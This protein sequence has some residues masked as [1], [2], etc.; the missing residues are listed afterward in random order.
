MRLDDFHSTDNQRASMHFSH[1]P[2]LTVSTIGTL[3]KRAGFCPD[4]R[5]AGEPQRHSVVH[6]EY[7]Q[8][9]EETVMDR[10]RV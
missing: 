7:R 5:F 4:S 8:T 3:A 6:A 9:W 10:W 2:R 1:I